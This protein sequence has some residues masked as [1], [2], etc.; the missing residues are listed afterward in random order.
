MMAHKMWSKLGASTHDYN[1][2]F[3]TP[4]TDALYEL[5]PVEER[6]LIKVGIF[7]SPQPREGNSRHGRQLDMGSDM[8]ESAYR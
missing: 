8:K 2:T 4:T 1:F 6:S 7:A 3:Q 5:L